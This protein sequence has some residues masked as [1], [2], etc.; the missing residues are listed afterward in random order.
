MEPRRLPPPPQPC[1][2]LRIHV[3]FLLP[4]RMAED[5]SYHQPLSSNEQLVRNVSVMI[6]ADCLSSDRDPPVDTQYL[7]ISACWA[8]VAAVMQDGWEEKNPQKT[9]LGWPRVKVP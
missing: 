7:W 1:F 6:P 2:S 9:H 4:S 3:A 5:R 8:D